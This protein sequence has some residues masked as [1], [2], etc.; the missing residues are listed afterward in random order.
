MINTTWTRDDITIAITEMEGE[1]L[2][3]VY[4]VDENLRTMNKSIKLSQEDANSLSILLVLSESI[5]QRRLDHDDEV[6]TVACDL[7][8]KMLLALED[9]EI[10]SGMVSGWL[11]NTLGETYGD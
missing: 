1:G 5:E 2:L 6:S 3:H 10:R 9:L 11:V 8:D 4:W 7:Y